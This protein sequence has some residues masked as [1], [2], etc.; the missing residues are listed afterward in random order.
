[1]RV[2]TGAMGI[3]SP[4]GGVIEACE[5]PEVDVGNQTQWKKKQMFLPDDP[6][7]QPTEQKS[8]L[9]ECWKI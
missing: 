4:E 3:R 1:M 7:L 5:L 8:M 9:S 2:P 6:S